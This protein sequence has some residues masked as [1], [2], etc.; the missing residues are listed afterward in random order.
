MARTSIL[1]DA[2]GT[3]QAL[4][5]AGLDLFGRN[6]FDATSTREIAQA[7]KVNSAGI[8]YHFGGKDGLRQ[9]CAEAIIARMQAVLAGGAPAVSMAIDAADRDVAAEQLLALIDRVVTFLTT[10]PESEMIARF[11]V[12]E[13]LTPSPAFEA[14]YGGLFEP[15]HRR[16]CQVW[17]A[18]TGMEP[19]AP[20]TRLAVFAAIGQVVYFRIARPAVTRRMGWDGIGPEEARAIG[21]TV[22]RSV[23]ASILACRGEAS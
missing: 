5:R 7:A 21:E 22:R 16:V 12:R 11:V 20:A 15:V 8:A 23:R 6:G 18:A 4:I 19:E 17:A 3:R 9:A 13:M 10:V 2:E 14:I 1:K